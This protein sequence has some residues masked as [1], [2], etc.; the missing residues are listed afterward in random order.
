MTFIV[1]VVGIGCEAALCRLV[2]GVYALAC[3]VGGL[4]SVAA[5]HTG[6]GEIGAIIVG[7]A[8]GA[9]TLAAGQLIFVVARSR[10]TRIVVALFFVIPA[11]LAGHSITLGLAQWLDVPSVV[12][13]QVYAIAGAIM[14]GAAALDRLEHP[15]PRDSEWQ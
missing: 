9:F 8:A 7:M 10:V 12:W 5:Y 14:V 13:Q 11:A 4:A 6:A 2:F 3:V 15:E 1:I